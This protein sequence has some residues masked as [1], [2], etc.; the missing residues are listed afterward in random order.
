MEHSDIEILSGIL[1]GA[2]QPQDAIV[3]SWL[4]EDPARSV[5]LKEP[6]ELRRLLEELQQQRSFDADAMWGRFVVAHQMEH[7]QASGDTAGLGYAEEVDNKGRH[8]VIETGPATGKVVWMRYRRAIGWAAAVILLLG[9]VM[10]WRMRSV[11]SSHEKGLVAAAQKPVGNYAVLRAGKEEVDL[12]GGDSSFVLGGNQVQVQGGSMQVAATK[13]VEYTL[14][15]PRGAAYQVQ[16]PDGSKAW[17]NAASSITYPS[18]FTGGERVVT[19]SGEVYLDVAAVAS[20]PFIVHTRGQEIRVLGTAFCVRDYEEDQQQLTTLVS[21]KVQVVADGK[22]QL[23]QPGEQAVL[24]DGRM[25][26]QQVNTE[27]YTSWKDGWIR[28]NNK[29]LNSIL[30]TISRWYNVDINTEHQLV[31]GQFFTCYLD[32]NQSLGELLQSLNNSTNQFSFSLQGSTITV[33]KK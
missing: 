23:L 11:E 24:K 17:L 32:K 27:E 15:T 1:S 29:P 8:A 16:L 6:A 2:L 18:A 31:S 12:H 14:T 28:F 3:Q 33:T 9:G 4:Q 21:G 19:V 7:E 26:V 10:F 22:Q 25:Q 5:L 30:Q 13:P 20:Q